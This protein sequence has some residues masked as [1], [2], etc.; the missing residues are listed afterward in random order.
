LL[1]DQPIPMEPAGTREPVIR[2]FRK[3][4][5]VA[6]CACA[7]LAAMVAVAFADDSGGTALGTP[8]TTTVIATTPTTSALTTTP[9]T[10]TTDTG[11]TTTP[12]PVTSAPSAIPVPQQNPFTGRAMWIWELRDTDHGDIAA[13][14]AKAERYQITTLMI[15]SSDGTTRWSQFSR[16]LVSDLHE[17]GIKVCAW[18]FVYGRNPIAE[19]RVGAGAVREGADCL[20]IDAESSYQGRYP[21]ADD[22]IGALRKRIGLS[23]PVALA[24]FPYVDFHLNFPYSV[25]LGPNGAQYNLPQMY[26]AD[27]G[28]SVSY[29]FSHTYEYNEIYRRPIYPLGQLYGKLSAGAIEQFNT[30]A[31]EFGAA[32]VSWWDWQS[33]KSSYFTD[34]DTDPAPPYGFKL[35]MAAATIKR[36]GIGDP[37]IWAQELLDGAGYH[38]A[39]DGG[40]GVNTQNAVESFQLNHGLAVTGQVDAATWIALDKYTPVK[41]RWTRTKNGR[42]ISIVSP[43]ASDTRDQSVATITATVPSWAATVPTRNELHGQIGAGGSADPKR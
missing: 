33:A 16:T 42:L 28:D 4:T 41:V 22:Y 36:R 13:I 1:G 18:Q 9:A 15:K 26:W 5:F 38:L 2:R 12:A 34:I 20:V 37:V 24:G 29:V 19:A 17:A 7:V 27:I 25:F 21:A 32:G 10:T 35:S 8:T 40:F 39:I 14:I 11:I 31:T 23:F 3:L 30:L 43:T 6:A